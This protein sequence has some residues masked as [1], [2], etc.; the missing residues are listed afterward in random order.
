MRMRVISRKYKYKKRKEKKWIK[1]ELGGGRYIYF[2][3]G[4]LEIK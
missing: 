2:R 3:M 4:L 1:K